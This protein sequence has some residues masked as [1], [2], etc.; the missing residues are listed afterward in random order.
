MAATKFGRPTPLLAAGAV[1][2]FAL[3][4]AWL[5]PRGPVTTVEALATMA[6]A[7]V[8]GLVVG[9][10]T[11]SRASLVLAPAATRPS[12]TVSR[13]WDHRLTTSPSARAPTSSGPSAPSTRTPSSTAAA[14]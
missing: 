6:A 4:S 8:V 11:G 3:A 10:A 2:A 9:V 12:W 1:L 13:R 7:L 14:R 5:V